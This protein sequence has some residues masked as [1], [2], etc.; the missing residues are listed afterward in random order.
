MISQSDVALVLTHSGKQSARGPRTGASFMP[1]MPSSLPFT[2][3]ISEA[4]CRGSMPLLAAESGG[5]RNL[6]GSV[7][8]GARRPQAA[9]AHTCAGSRSVR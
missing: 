4:W 9:A 2:P 5:H 3:I 7:H 8:Y 1:V 6:V